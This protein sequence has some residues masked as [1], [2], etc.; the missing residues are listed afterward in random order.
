MEKMD[1]IFTFGTLTV[2]LYSRLKETYYMPL[3]TIYNI[4]LWCPQ[5]VSEVSAQYPTDNYIILKMLILSGLSCLL[6]CVL[7]HITLNF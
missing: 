1:E 2:A 6:H 7:N 3:F 4:S 5:N